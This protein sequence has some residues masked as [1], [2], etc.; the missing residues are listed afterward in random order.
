MMRLNL[1][2]GYKLLA[3]YE[4]IDIWD[5]A[6]VVLNLEDAKL[7]YDSNSV[8][9][10]IAIDFFEHIRNFVPLM[11]ECWRVIA[12]GGVMKIEVPR[13]PSDAAFADPTHVRFFVPDS[14]RYFTEWHEGFPMY[15]IKPWEKVEQTLTENRIAIT[16]RKHG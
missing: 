12:P 16:L 11:N 1:G 15:H 9:E 10:I 7:P 5:G 2:C 6:P 4:N 3:G 13:A 8:E 14:F